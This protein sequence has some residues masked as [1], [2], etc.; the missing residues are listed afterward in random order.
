MLLEPVESFINEA[1]SR[2]K[3]SESGAEFNQSGYRISWKGI[4]DRSNS[5]TFFKGA[6]QSFDPAA[7][8]T[9][10][11]RVGY[12]PPDGSDD[13]ESKFDVIWCQWCLGHLKDD[14]LVRFLERS[15][16]A[17]RGVKSLIVVKENLCTEP[18]NEPTTIFDEQDS[19]LTRFVS[20][21]TF[22][23]KKSLL[24]F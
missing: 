2:G 8:G 17:L 3:A 15:K 5:V 18:N 14:D 24:C 11:D 23:F 16:R 12:V 13:A 21:L 10:L 22:V 9:P 20:R 1:L 19:T 7:P 6:L 4:A